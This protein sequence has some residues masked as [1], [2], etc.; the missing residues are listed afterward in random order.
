MVFP[1]VYFYRLSTTHSGTLNST[2]HFY[3]YFSYTKV[4]Y[5]M[6]TIIKIKLY[7]HT[8]TKVIGLIGTR[9]IHYVYNT[10]LIIILMYS[11]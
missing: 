1:I 2:G 7:L 10:Q 11:K 4:S 3:T 5:S 8:K 6:C 9:P